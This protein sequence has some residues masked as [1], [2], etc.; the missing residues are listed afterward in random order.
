MIK[1]YGAEKSPH[2]KNGYSRVTIAV[3]LLYRIRVSKGN[4][5]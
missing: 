2:A 3:F 1:L 5:P 4:R